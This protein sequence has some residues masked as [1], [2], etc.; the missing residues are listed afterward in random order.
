MKFV[1]NKISKINIFLPI[2]LIS[3][4]YTVYKF[5][6]QS[7]VDGGLILS[8]LI[9]YPENFSNLTGAI[10]DF[11]LFYISLLYFF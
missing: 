3:F 4:Y 1:V 7:A 11:I 8:N 10:Q 9:N 5:E 6:A 2:I